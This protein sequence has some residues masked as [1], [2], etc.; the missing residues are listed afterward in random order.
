MYIMSN[1]VPGPCHIHI[2]VSQRAVGLNWGSLNK[3]IN[4]GIKLCTV[5]VG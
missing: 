2:K 4:A 5:T 3:K 1:N